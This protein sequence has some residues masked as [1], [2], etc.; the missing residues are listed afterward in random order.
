MRQADVDEHLRNGR[1][2]NLERQNLITHSL[3]VSVATDS[4]NKRR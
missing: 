3:I 2:L 1:A 4:G